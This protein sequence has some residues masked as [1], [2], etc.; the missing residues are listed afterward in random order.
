MSTMTIKGQVTIPKKLRDAAGFK[1]GDDIHARL[2]SSGAILLEKASTAA[3]YRKRIEEVASRRLIRDGMTTDE[4]ME[5]S[6]GESAT[7]ERPKK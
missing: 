2:T 7:W 5:F 3:D 6:R 4:F 1:P